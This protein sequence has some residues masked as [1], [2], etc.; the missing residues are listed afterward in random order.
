MAESLRF[1]DMR[2]VRDFELFLRR[3][4]ALDG[5]GAL[6]LTTKRVHKQLVLGVTGCVLAPHSLLDDTPVILGVRGFK[7]AAGVEDLD[8]VYQL[9]ALS[10]RLPR[11]AEP[12]LPLPPTETTSVWAGIAP[13]QTG[14]RAQGV[15]SAASLSEV[16]KTGAQQIANALP[17]NPGELLVQKLRE[18]VW[19][20]EILPQVPAG[21]A[22]ALDTL[23]FLH[24]SSDVK[25]LS[26]NGWLRLEAKGGSV[27][28]RL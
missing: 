8:A 13:P 1:P 28:V 21:A 26:A 17:E 9:R 19:A 15:V 7:L 18:E 23:G 11:L 24:G 16:A 22:F 20:R 12:Q 4:V 2:Y 14:W 6:R 5:A 10:E 3:F 25:L 27:L